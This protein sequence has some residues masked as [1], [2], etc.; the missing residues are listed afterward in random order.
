MCYLRWPWYS[1]SRTF[2][3]YLYIH[4]LCMK[5]SCFPV[6]FLFG[7]GF[8][9]ETT[10]MKDFVDEQI[11][12]KHFGSDFFHYCCWLQMPSKDAEKENFFLMSSIKF[13]LSF[14]F[15]ENQS[16]KEEINS[17]RF[18]LFLLFGFFFFSSWNTY[19]NKVTLFFLKN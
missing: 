10:C 16:R 6:F 15:L 3:L 14:L 12:I 9:N 8:R 19:N 17:Q 18:L 7:S 4:L 13:I 11:K 2:V 5:E 1:K